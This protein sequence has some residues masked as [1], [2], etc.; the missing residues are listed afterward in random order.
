MSIVS[1]QCFGT[2]IVNDFHL[3]DTTSVSAFKSA[4][5][6]M[7][8]ISGNVECCLRF[9]C[10]CYCVLALVTIMSLIMIFHDYLD[11]DHVSKRIGQPSME[12]SIKV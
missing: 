12:R 10:R 11:E 7:R 5:E 1:V 6:A 4:A 8:Y 2:I 9:P 3:L